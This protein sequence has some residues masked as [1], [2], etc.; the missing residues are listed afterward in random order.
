MNLD[1]SLYID[2]IIWIL[3]TLVNACPKWDMLT[4]VLGLP[5][6]EIENS[7]EETNNKKRPKQTKCC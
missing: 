3:E 4:T 7:R 1:H 5:Q 6:H 2:D